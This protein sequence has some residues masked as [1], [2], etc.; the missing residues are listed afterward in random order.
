M[1]YSGQIGI[2]IYNVLD[3]VIRN[4]EFRDYNGRGI[5]TKGN[6]T[7]GVVSGCSFYSSADATAIVIFGVD[8]PIGETPRADSNWV[9]CPRVIEDNEVIVNEIDFGSA[10]W[11]FIEDCYFEGGGMQSPQTKVQSMFSG[12]MSAITHPASNRRAWIGIRPS[13][14][15]QGI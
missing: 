13:S 9:A 4:C 2:K 11:V 8:N 3:F 1:A 12:T 7:R 6:A 14:R 10:D 5:E 15:K